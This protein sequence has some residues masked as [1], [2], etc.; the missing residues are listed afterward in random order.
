MLPVDLRPEV[1]SRV[2]SLTNRNVIAA[3]DSPSVKSPELTLW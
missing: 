3:H 2:L 1:S